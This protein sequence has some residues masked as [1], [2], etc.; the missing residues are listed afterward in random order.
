[1]LLVS[2]LGWGQS[3][4]SPYTIQFLNSMKKVNLSGDSTA[5]KRYRIYRSPDTKMY[6][7]A[8]I[9]LS[10][11]ESLNL[12]EEKGVQIGTIAGKIITARLPIDK[13]QEV[14][15]M[16]IVEY[17][18]MGTP[19]YTTMDEAKVSVRADKVHQGIELP[20]EFRGKD[21]VVGVIDDGFDYGHPNF[22]NSDKTEFRIKR[23]WDQNKKGK[24]PESY[25]Y[26]TEY[27][28]E[29]SI[30]SALTDSEESTH[31]THVLGIAAGADHTNGHQYGGI[32]TEADLT[33][34][35]LNSDNMISGDNTTIIDGINYIFNY[36]ESVEKPCVINLSLGSYMGPHDGSSAFDQMADVLQGPG[37]LIVGAVGN[38]GSSK[39]HLSKKFSSERK[40]TLRTFIEFKQIYP[41]ISF[42]EIWGEA[43][44]EY[45]FVPVIYSIHENKVVSSCESVSI[46]PEKVGNKEY[47]FEQD[48]DHIAGSMVITSE[49]N[50][51]NNKPHMVVTANFFKSD[52]YRAGFYIISNGDGNVHVWADNYYSSL[53]NFGIQGFSDGNSDSSMGEI[54]GTG[55]RIISVGA[56]TTRDH[57]YKYGIYY[58]TGEELASI[59]SFSSRGPTPD[60]RVKPDITSPGTYIISSLSSYC[61]KGKIKAT[62][63]SWNGKV[64]DFGYMQGTSMASPLVV[65]I[66]ATWLQADSELTPEKVREILKNTSIKDQYTGT[67]PEDGSNIWGQGKIDA[68]NGLKE[69]IRRANEVNEVIKDIPSVIILNKDK[70]C[71]LLF[72]SNQTTVSIQLYNVNGTEIYNCKLNSVNAGDEYSIKLNNESAGIYLVRVVSDGC[73]NSQKIIIQ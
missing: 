31:G 73:L 33:L 24:A 32:A 53:S 58:P 56:Y 66:L 10:H 50:P 12:F 49:I 44:M 68:W 72:T 45:N 14:A 26:G 40:D 19:V 51:N 20:G 60:G 7:S 17:I 67:I 22:W 43:N 61:D 57:Y 5:L 38:D 64:Y 1:M 3:K 63:I 41:Q 59:S 13:I 36:A 48:K 30:L 39:T 62:S 28:T 35:S 55:K 15:D 54:G 70:Q 4:L 52:E 34:V 69:C 21:I 71:C 42:I 6:I 23:V 29:E 46:S 9:R 18:E 65:G 25:A 16:T 8:F 37:K 11:T 27:K 47:A 2:I